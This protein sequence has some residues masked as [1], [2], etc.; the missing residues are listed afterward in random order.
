MQDRKSRQVG[1]CG[2]E[3]S[4]IGLRVMVE[5]PA[6]VSAA[7]PAVTGW[8][9]CAGVNGEWLKIDF[10]TCQQSDVDD[11]TCPMS[12]C[13]TMATANSHLAHAGPHR[14]I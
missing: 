14:R 12:T 3:R 10:S 7:V 5:L 2:A 11:V 9:S 1:W 4:E 13:G 6:G 8:L